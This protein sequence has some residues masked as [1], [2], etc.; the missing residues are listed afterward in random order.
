MKDAMDSVF[1]SGLASF[2]VSQNQMNSLTLGSDPNDLLIVHNVGTG[3]ETHLTLKADGNAEIKSQF[4]VKVIG[5]DIELAASNSLTLSAQQ[6]NVNVPQTSW[7]G[8]YTMVGETRFNGVLFD[9]HIHS[10]VM[11]GPSSTGP[12]AG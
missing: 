5:K 12:V 1:V 3:Q 9:T 10:G 11:S 2:S 8:S 7:T 6:M 4:T